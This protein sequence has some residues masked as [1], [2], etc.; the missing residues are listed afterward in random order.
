MQILIR[1]DASQIIGSG[2][3]MRCRNLAREL[4]RRGAEV[5][6]ICRVREG[7]LIKMIS[8]EF[9][10]L[11]LPPF[12][13]PEPNVIGLNGRTLY[14][15]WLGCSQSEDI[16]D[17]IDAINT[18]LDKPV[19]WLVVDHYGLDHSWESNIRSH[20]GKLQGFSPELL[21]FDDLLDRPHNASVIVDPNRFGRMAL[22]AYQLHVQEGCRLCLG[23][24]YAPLDTLYSQLQFLAPQRKS[25]QRI[26]VFFGS[27][28]YRNYTTSALEA[29]STPAL[30]H[31]GVDV[32]LGS[33][34][35]HFNSVQSLVKHRP[36]TSF[37]TDLLS[38]CG[39]ILRADLAIGGAGV[40][41]WER[42]ALSLPTLVIPVA[43]NQQTVATILVDSGAAVK[44]DL[45]HSSDHCDQIRRAIISIVNNPVILSQMSSASL[46]LTDARGL[47]RLS[48][49]I[50]GP[51]SVRS[52][53]QAT[54]KD[55]TTYCLWAN[56]PE[57]RAQSLNTD[58]IPPNTHD[59][60]FI[61][62]LQS[63]KTLLYIM[64]DKE[65]LA[66]G[67]I[68]FDFVSAKSHRAKISFSIDQVVR[69]CGLASE[70]LAL[71]VAELANHS[72][73]PVEAFA[74]VRKTNVP[75]I[76][77]FLRAGFTEITSPQDS[78]RCFL[79]LTHAEPR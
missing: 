5:V 65:G 64:E 68:R 50:M 58:F 59:S 44:I 18:C 49:I 10:V 60:W 57:T 25:V 78:L 34:S 13:D 41:S 36:N 53:R 67:Q 9:R 71:G 4:Q 35:P 66:L 39:L 19:H 40:T 27:T 72:N 37:H 69:G 75:S 51:G 3:V 52:L 33:A 14:S 46:A 8:E 79:M 30:S 2:H 1:C 31:V 48:T 23:P 7:D 61:G 28:D 43:D 12:S 77:A 22:H 20:I 6:F 29:L 42:A 63:D 24:A 32:V 16:C 21:A 38:L 54:W 76:R 17:C 55:K 45:N 73:I 62:S 15:A 56:D 74:E 26:L 11:C 47:S 70:L